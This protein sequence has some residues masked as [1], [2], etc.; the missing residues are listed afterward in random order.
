MNTPNE[1]NKLLSEC[2]VQLVDCSD[3]IKQMPLAPARENIYRLGKALAEISEIRS[4]LYKSHPHLKPE[5]WDSPPSENDYAEMYQEALRQ[6]DEYLQAGKPEK[7]V[8]TFE[9]YILISPTEKYEGKAKSE[10][11]KLRK[12]YRV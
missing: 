9:S 6:T 12:K 1:L 8:E 7:A 5:K 3:I 2:C 4:A 11:D 10:I